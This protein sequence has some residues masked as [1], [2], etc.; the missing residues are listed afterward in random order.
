M[1]RTMKAVVKPKGIVG[2]RMMEVPI[3]SVGPRDVLVK[4]KACSICGTDIHIYNSDP[5]IRDVVAHNQI[6]GHEVCGEIAEVGAEVRD[7]AVGDFVALESHV[8]CSNCYYCLNGLRRLCRELQ[9]IGIDRPGGYAEYIA[10]PAENA[11]LMPEGISPDVAACLEPFGNAVD[12]ALCVALAGKSVLITGCGPQG[13]MALAVARA[14]GARQI[15]ASEVVPFRRKLAG[16][17]LREHTRE[18]L[19]K[20]DMILDP[21][22]VDTVAEVLRA[23]DGLGV[24][25]VLEMSGHPNAIRDAGEVLKSGGDFVALGL[26]RGEITFDWAHA[27]VYKAA[28]YHGIYGR[29]LFQAWTTG[30][31]LVRSGAVKLEL[32]I[33][34]RMSLGDFEEAFQILRRGEGAK[35]ILYPQG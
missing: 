23:T 21:V 22:E 24:D 3:P 12:T 33:T 17:V 28:T 19:G 16:E 13:L 20:R 30:L 35:V 34:H 2:L 26:P 27:F 5:V 11:I 10:V 18:G 25:V 8:V 15:I 9:T 29:R 32:L 6:L 1:P 14:A 4:V 7:R 31:E